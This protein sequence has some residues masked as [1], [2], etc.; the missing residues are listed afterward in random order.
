MAD[1]T[2]YPEPPQA[3]VEPSAKHALAYLGPGVIIASVT[4]GSGELVHASRSEAIFGY[5]MLWCFF[6][7]GLFKAIQVY[8]AGRYITLT[9]EHPRVM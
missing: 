4:I 8:T 1:D 7:A 6:Y 2:L 3:L 9:G 5:G